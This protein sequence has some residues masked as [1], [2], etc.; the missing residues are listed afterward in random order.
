[1]PTMHSKTLGK[2]FNMVPTRYRLAKP[3]KTVTF[4]LPW[5]LFNSLS[6]NSVMS[7]EKQDYRNGVM[8]LM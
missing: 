3:V 4:I 7:F 5:F 6:L 1:M 8:L 2:N